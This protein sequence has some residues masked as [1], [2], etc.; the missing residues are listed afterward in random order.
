MDPLEKKESPQFQGQRPTESNDS[1]SRGLGVRLNLGKLSA[2]ELDRIPDALKKLPE[3]LEFKPGMQLVIGPNG[4][5]KTV[6]IEAIKFAGLAKKNN[7]EVDAMISKMNDQTHKT[8]HISLMMAKALELSDPSILHLDVSRGIERKKDNERLYNPMKAMFGYDRIDSGS[9][10]MARDRLFEIFK[11]E[12]D[13]SQFKGVILLDE[14]ETGMDPWRH[15]KIREE[16]LGHFHP[17]ATLIIATNSPIL[18]FDSTLSRIDLR[19]PEDG[20]KSGSGQDTP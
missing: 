4:T 14:P 7:L 10:R 20:M 3:S 1:D 13:L 18:A 5:G 12:K 11:G 2:K 8:H 6:L 19:N 15:A 17:E 16:L 9:A